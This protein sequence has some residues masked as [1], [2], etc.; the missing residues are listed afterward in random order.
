MLNINKYTLD[1]VFC[2]KIEPY[3]DYYRK[4]IRMLNNTAHHILKNEIGLILL[5]LPTKQKCNIITMQVSSIIG[6]AYEGIASF[7]HNRRHKALHKAVNTMDSKTT[8]Q[9]YK[10]MHLEDSMI[11]YG[12]YNGET[13]GQLINTVHCIH[14]TTSS[15]DK[16]FAGQQ[17]T[18]IL[19]SLYAN[20]QGI[21]HYSIN[22]LLHLRTVKDK[23]VLLYKDLVM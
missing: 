16:L 17:G 19:Q 2:K 7:P 5:Q 22:S 18:A 11:M 12:F 8:I 10:L 4:Q 20:V 15:N 21:Q 9:H 1:L 3:V 6:L 23:Y 13:L 14:N